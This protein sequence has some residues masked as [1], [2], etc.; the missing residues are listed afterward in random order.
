MHLPTPRYFLPGGPRGDRQEGTI[1]NGILRNHRILFAGLLGA[2][3]LAGTPLFA[4]ADQ[5]KWWNPKQGGTKQETR[6]RGEGRG[7]Q[8][9]NRTY[10]GWNNGPRFQR[11]IVVIR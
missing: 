7:W 1:M 8:N 6:N 9:G 5:G 10:R 4:Q 2:A 3:V 11:D